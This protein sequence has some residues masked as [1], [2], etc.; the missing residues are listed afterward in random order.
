MDFISR[1]VISI[2][3]HSKGK[4]GSMKTLGNF[5]PPEARR[6]DATAA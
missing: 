4:G 2:K 5:N 6:G 3:P 1:Q